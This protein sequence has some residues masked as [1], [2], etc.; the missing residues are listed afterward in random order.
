MRSESFGRLLKVGIGSIATGEGKTLPAIEDELRQ[1]IGL[2]GASIQRYKAGHLPPDLR[3]IEILA[4]AA[5][6]RGYL[7]RECLQIFLYAAQ[8]PAPEQL[9]DKLCPP[10]PVRQRPPRIYETFPPRPAAS[11]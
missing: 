8:Y 5:V 1:Q 2:T 7:N 3:T 11:S 6:K 9:L 10:G 4:E